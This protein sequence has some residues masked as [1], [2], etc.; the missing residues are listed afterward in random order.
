MNGILPERTINKFQCSVGLGEGQ[1]VPQG[2]WGPVNKNGACAIP[3]ETQLATFILPHNGTLL[4]PIT[5]TWS[6]YS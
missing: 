4:L 3:S 1:P 6:I 5:V 2:K